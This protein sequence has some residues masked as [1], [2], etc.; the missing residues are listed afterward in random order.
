MFLEEPK[1]YEIIE[2]VELDAKPAAANQSEAHC[3]FILGSIIEKSINL[4]EGTR[5]D[6]FSYE[7]SVIHIP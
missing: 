5:P 3:A 2:D 6:Y 7:Y 1:S 4:I